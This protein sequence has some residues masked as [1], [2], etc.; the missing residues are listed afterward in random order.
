MRE[1]LKDIGNSERHTFIGRFERT[2]FKRDYGKTAPWYVD[3]Y[4]GIY[5]PTL[6][7]THVQ[8]QAT[9]EEVTNH[10]WFNYTKTFRNLGQL[11][12][13]DVIQFDARI[14]TY[15]KGLGEDKE[16]DYKLERPTKIKMIKK[17]DGNREEIPSIEEKNALIGYIIVQNKKFYDENGRDYSKYYIE[18]YEHWKIS[19]QTK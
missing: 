12:I 3:D 16:L 5:K 7:L 8:L 2:G 11:L 14:T 10:L 9:G 1:R 19:S 18:Q 15:I 13:G 6:L 17:A 4:D